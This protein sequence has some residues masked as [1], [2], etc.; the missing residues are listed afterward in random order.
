M[1]VGAGEDLAKSSSQFEGILERLVGHLKVLFNNDESQIAS[2][3]VVDERTCPY[4]ILVTNIVES[5]GQYLDGFR[6]NNLKYRTDLAVREIA[7]VL[8]SE[9]NQI[10]TL[11]KGRMNSYYQDKAAIDTVLKSKRYQLSA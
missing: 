8:L 2:S 3:L 6:W 9:V 5:P 4:R 11:I 7:D 1:L 10:D